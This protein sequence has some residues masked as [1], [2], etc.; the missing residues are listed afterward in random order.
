MPKYISLLNWTDQ[1]IKNFKESGERADQAAALAEKMGGRF[2]DIY[3][4]Q[5]QYDIVA[6]SEF[7]DDETA[8]AFLLQVGGL[9]NIR[10]TTLRAFD[11]QTFAKIVEKAG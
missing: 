1:G 4:T 6:V 5:G 7:P 2:E 10:S 8:T 9:G 11:R 3:W